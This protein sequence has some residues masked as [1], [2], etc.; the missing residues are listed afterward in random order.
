MCGQRQPSLVPRRN[1]RL[2]SEVQFPNAASRLRLLHGSC[3]LF[4]QPREERE[5]EILEKQLNQLRLSR[6]LSFIYR[7][8]REV[9]SGSHSHTSTTRMHGSIHTYIY[10]YKID[11]CTNGIFP[12]GPHNVVV[13]AFTRILHFGR[14]IFAR[15]SGLHRQ[16]N[17][18]TILLNALF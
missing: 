3:T 8:L 1:A 2:Q 14:L 13:E 6:H 12:Q 18:D 7:P 17:D 10:I 4:S 11:F 5:G 16:P 15:A 9:M